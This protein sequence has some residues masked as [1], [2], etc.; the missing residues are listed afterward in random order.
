MKRCI[1]KAKLGFLLAVLIFICHINTPL[2]AQTITLVESIPLRLAPKESSQIILRAQKGDEINA[3]SN[4]SEW[5]YLSYKSKNY[6]TE[7]GNL[8][9]VYDGLYVGISEY[10]VSAST[11]PTC[12]Y[13]LP[14]SGSNS[15]FDRPLAKM[16]HLDPLGLLFGTHE[17]SPC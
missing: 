13:G 9:K 10:P 8:Y 2:S 6:Y 14:Y 1:E 11:D 12:D 5:V 7:Y 15:F 16:R 17:R 4:T 3:L